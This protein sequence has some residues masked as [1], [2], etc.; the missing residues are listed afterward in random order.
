MMQQPKGDLRRSW[1][2]RAA[3]V[4]GVIA[5]VA[6]IILVTRGP[7]LDLAWLQAQREALEATV[8]ARPIAAS[9]AYFVVYLAVIALSIP[10]ATVL[11]LA[12]GALFGVL[13]GSVLV[14]FASTIGATAAF[15]I[16]RTLLRD[17]VQR[18]FAKRLT[19]LNAGVLRE[20]GLYLFAL[21]MAPVVPFFVINV[22]MALT[23]LRTWTFYW[24]SQLGM[25]PATLIYVNAGSQLAAIEEPADIVS[26]PVVVSLL[27]LGL[28][29][30]L[31]KRLAH[32]AG[33]RTTPP[34][35]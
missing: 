21:R 13:W 26:P 5:V 33:A 16:A 31:A 9:V 12:G 20:G 27:L 25:L 10:G 28:F 18:R 17:W 34:D 24:V 1:W 15:L 3:L 35:T 6:A 23:P 30:L 19:R 11:T 8:S 14:S 7:W 22:V 2:L 32:L 29:P 4:A